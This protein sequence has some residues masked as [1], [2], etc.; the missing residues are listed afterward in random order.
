M[1][2][3]FKPRVASKLS[4][5]DRVPY[6]A[7]A[8]VSFETIDTT[9]KG[10]GSEVYDYEFFVRHDGTCNIHMV[11][12]NLTSYS[13]DYMQGRS[14]T[15]SA[16]VTPTVTSMPILICDNATY[17]SFAKIKITGYI[18]NKRHIQVFSGGHDGATFTRIS[19]FYT[20]DTSSEITSVSFFNTISQTVTFT[21]VGFAV[22]KIQYNPH[23]IL[24][25]HKKLTNHTAD[26]IFGGVNDTEGVDDLDGDKYDYFIASNLDT[27]SSS[28]L[29]FYINDDVA[30]GRTR[31]YLA[32][33]SG[34]LVSANDTP[35]LDG[36]ST[37]GCFAKI[38]AD[39]GRK[40]LTTLSRTRVPTTF[41]QCESSIWNPDTSTPMKSLM[42]RPSASISGDI[43]LY[44]VPKGYNADLTQW[45]FRQVVDINGD[46]SAGHSFK[47]PSWALFMKVEYTGVGNASIYTKI[48]GDASAVYDTQV[49]SSE[50]SSTSAIFSSNGSIAQLCQLSTSVNSGEML[51]SLK[52]GSNRS[53]LNTFYS[54]EDIIQNR[55]FWY[56]NSS[57]PV[58]SYLCYA[59]NSNT[60]KGKL[61]VSFI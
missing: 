39:T 55:A 31:Q 36:V 3:P 51:W 53:S 17:T 2:I 41:Q 30:T 11:L 45:T 24:L 1:T 12:N 58:T 19:S 54:A 21:C 4:A 7:T 52:T 38:H 35:N 27:T 50:A 61:V 8:S 9:V 6:S 47:V 29:F 59:S 44:A 34:T 48:N 22:P 15:P 60:I 25:K 5:L 10:D 28:S 18:G 56:K 43:W 42:L 40:K 49:L 57:T 37:N 16:D 13:Q 26:I 23:A 33:S 14:S 32:N 20:A 46:F